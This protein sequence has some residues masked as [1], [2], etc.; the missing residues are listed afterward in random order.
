MN[1]Y[2]SNFMRR[3]NRN[4]SNRADGATETIVLEN[5]DPNVEQGLGKTFG[6]T[7]TNGKA[8]NVALAL[9]PAN[10]D[11]ERL[12]ATTNESGGVYTTTIARTFDNIAALN[13]AGFTVGAVLADGTSSYTAP[14]GTVVNFTCTANDP[15]RTIKELLD[16]IKFN[17][18]RLK[19]IDIITSNSNMFQGN[20]SVTFCNPF[21]KNRVQTVQMTTF[22]SRFQYATDRIGIDFADNSLEFSDLLLFTCVIPASA[23]VQFIMTFY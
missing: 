7:V 4:L 21:Y 1:K 16:Y 18:Q 9:V 20:L 12:V 17:P 10:Y 15:Q 2:Q 19:H 3:A 11:T 8:S 6:V 5:T 22:Y 13:A 23:T 14:D